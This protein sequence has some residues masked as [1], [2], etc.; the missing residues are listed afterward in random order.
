[1]KVLVAPD[2]FKGSLSAAAAAAAIAR[3]WRDAWPEC[4]VTLAPIADGGEGFA[5]IFHQALGAEWVELEA[6]DPLGR[7]VRARYAWLA[8]ERTAILEMSEASGLWRLRE[9][10]ARA[11]GGAHL[12]HGRAHAPCG[13]AGSAQD[14]RGARRERHYRWRRRDGGGARVRLSRGGWPRRSLPRRGTSPRVARIDAR[15]RD[16]AP[17]GDRRVRCGESAA[18]AARHGAGLFTAKRRGCG[19]RRRRWSAR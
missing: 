2:K 16:P 5:E 4:E 12:R 1:M 17:A 3:G 7:A 6:Q 8:A 11:A 13:G 9:E 18:R 10:R 14:S 15:A 19:R